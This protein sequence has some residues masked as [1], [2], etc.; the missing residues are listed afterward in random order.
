MSL[1]F[2]LLRVSPRVEHSF[3]KIMQS[4]ATIDV[5]PPRKMSSRYPKTK[6]EDN[7]TRIGCNGKQNRRGPNGS[8]SMV[9][10]N[11]LEAWTAASAP[12]GVPTPICRCDRYCVNLGTAKAL[13]LFDASLRQ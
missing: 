2:D 8:V 12:P 10:K 6:G 1:H 13:A 7:L 11:H 5:C 4:S 9:C 3:S